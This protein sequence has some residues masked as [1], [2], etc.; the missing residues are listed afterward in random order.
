MLLLK[1]RW[2]PI[3]LLNSVHKAIDVMVKCLSKYKL[4][5]VQLLLR[6]LVT[7]MVPLSLRLSKSVKQSL[8]KVWQ[9]RL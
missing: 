3:S 2:M 4:V 7:V 5:M 1:V 6:R 9:I 8:L